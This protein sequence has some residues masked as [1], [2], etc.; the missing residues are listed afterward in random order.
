[1]KKREFLSEQQIEDRYHEVFGV[2]IVVIEKELVV[3]PN[4]HKRTFVKFICPVHGETSQRLDRM[5]KVGCF[6]CKIDKNTRENGKLVYGVGFCDIAARG[7]EKHDCYVDWNS[8]L[9]RCYDQ[10]FHKRTPTYIGCSVCNEWQTFSNFY[11][12]WKRNHKDGFVLD[13]D[14][15]RKGNKIY[16]PETC[17]YIPQE[18]NN[19]MCRRQKFRGNLPI[20]VRYDKNKKTYLAS[21]SYHGYPQHIGCFETPQDAFKAYKKA[22]EEYIK[23]RAEEYKYVI[24]ERVYNA[25]M[26]YNV[27]IND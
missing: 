2:D 18:L 20:G 5:F 14:I 16:S 25:L 27:D 23:E 15:I 24:D 12:W 26:N 17:A 7:S 10:S 3:E 6:Q 1:M 8:M 19:L 4:G 13:K 11:E 9:Q 21:M 22:R